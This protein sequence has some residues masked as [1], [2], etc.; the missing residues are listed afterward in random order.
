MAI[1]LKLAER[2]RGVLEQERAFTEK[3]MFGGLCYLVRGHMACGITGQ[4]DLMVRVGPEAHPAALKL[5]HAR[6]MDFTG[7]PMKGFVFV[8]PEGLRTR[9]SLRTWIGRGLAFT[10]S[11]PAK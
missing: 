2:V 7:R 11:L 3:K 10:D 9:R 6:P 5:K 8:A 1:D 4:G